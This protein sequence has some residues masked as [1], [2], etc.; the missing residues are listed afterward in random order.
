MEIERLLV[1]LTKELKGSCTDERN[2]NPASLQPGDEA[3]TTIRWVGG[4]AGLINA[5]RSESRTENSIVNVA[6]KIGLTLYNHRDNIHG[7]T[8]KQVGCGYLALLTMEEASVVFEDQIIDVNEY[9]SQMTSKLQVP[10]LEVLDEHVAGKGG[11]L[12]NLHSNQAINPEEIGNAFFSLDLGVLK[13][14]LQQMAEELRLNEIDIEQALVKITR[15]NMAACYVL[16][17]RAIDANKFIVIGNAD[18]QM[19]RVIET[20]YEQLIETTRMQA[21]NEMIR[22][23]ANH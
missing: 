16:S 3:K 22:K 14:K 23:R 5:L 7:S 11:L 6:R 4:G 9:V 12:I 20:A 10:V 17:N 21:M 18:E 19:K 8:D 2:I 1:P 15:D 13:I